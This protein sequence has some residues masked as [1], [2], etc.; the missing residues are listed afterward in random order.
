LLHALS[1]KAKKE[2]MENK[3]EDEYEEGGGC[4]DEVKNCRDRWKFLE[5]VLVFNETKKLR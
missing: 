3:D 4:K 2:E 5:R 1:E